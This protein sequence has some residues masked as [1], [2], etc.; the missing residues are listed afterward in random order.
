M[1][2]FNG[3][4]LISSNTK[5]GGRNY[6]QHSLDFTN[7]WN[8]PA[9][10]GEI[11]NNRFLNGKTVLLRNNGGQYGNF[12]QDLPLELTYQDVTWSCFAKADNLGDELH[13]E[14][15]GSKGL[16]NQTLTTN[17]TRYV[18]HGTLNDNKNGHRM[19][20]FFWGQPTNKG[21]V[22]IALPKL[23]LG[24]LATDWTPAPEDF[25]N[26]RN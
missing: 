16:Y 3:K 10:N 1:I 22:Y 20:L 9:E 5:I 8:L 18:F 23:E 25:L 11:S 19:A 14:P 6:L 15:W 21:N 12:S 4:E 7:N 2:F 17:W 24:P 13:T 26:E